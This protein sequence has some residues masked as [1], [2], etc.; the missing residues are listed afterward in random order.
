VLGTEFAFTV[1][2]SAGRAQRRDADL[3]RTRIAALVATCS[4]AACSP[5]ASGS[6]DSSGSPKDAETGASHPEVG[7]Q[8]PSSEVC[9]VSTYALV[10]GL[11]L[12]KPVHYL[13]RDYAGAPVEEAGAPCYAADDLEDCASALAAIRAEASAS[14]SAATFGRHYYVYTRGSEVDVVVSEQEVLELLGPIDTVNEAAVVLSLKY[15]LTQ[16][17]KDISAVD[18]GYLTGPTYLR[19]QL[20]PATPAMC[21]RVGYFAVHVAHDGTTTELQRE[22]THGVCPGRSPAGLLAL[23]RT[24]PNLAAGAHFARVAQLELAAVAAFAEIERALAAHGAPPPLLERCRAARRDEVRHAALMTEL[25][26][27]YG[28]APEPV[29]FVPKA[30]HTLLE[31]ALENAREGTSRELFGAVVAAWQSRAAG[32]SDTRARYAEIARDEAEHAQFSHD[33]AAWLSE[34]LS[35]DEQLRVEHERECS[36]QALDLELDEAVDDEVA[37]VAGLPNASEAKR[38]LRALRAELA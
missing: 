24:D 19:R 37:R 27:R 7:R 32:S 4:A 11:H 10:F 26:C 9:N 18:D 12:P 1:G 17:C 23:A 25:A 21:E 36:F 29:R 3:L 13:A 38:L 28:V 6:G 8:A 35:A 14:P 30:S 16:R 15:G 34:R 2:M 22:I 20:T 33:L 5:G 31:L